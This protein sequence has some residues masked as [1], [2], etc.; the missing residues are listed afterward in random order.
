MLPGARA[1]VTAHP[2]GEP[3]DRVSA[4]PRNGAAQTEYTGPAA[5]S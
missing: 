4:Y 2:R 1:G 5:L 3:E